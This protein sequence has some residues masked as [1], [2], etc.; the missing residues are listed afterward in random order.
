M[1]DIQRHQIIRK[2]IVAFGNLFNSIP[3]VRYN[4]DGTESERIIVSLSYAAKEQYIKRWYDDPELNSKVQVVIPQLS[5]EMT[6]VNYDASRKQNTNIKNF[7]HTQEGTFSQYNPVPYNFDFELA[8]YSRSIEDATQIV[9]YILPYFTPDYT[10]KVNLIPE[11]GLVKE[12]PII[13]NN[14]I[15]DVVYEGDRESDTRRIIWTFQFTVKG[16]IFGR[17]SDV[18]DKLITHSITSILDYASSDDIFDLTLNPSTGTGTYKVG[19]LVYQG[20][21]IPI[22]T[23]SGRVVSHNTTNNILKIKNINGNFVSNMPLVGSQSRTS[24]LYTQYSPAANNKLI[25]IDTT[26]SPP[27]ANVS[28]NWKANT[29]I[30]EFS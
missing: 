28:S 24:Y 21:S 30:T 18:S 13:L 14:T 11:M 25:Q 27:G 17:V 26:V 16:F 19:E 5:Y 10:I 29:V 3:L 15:R 6:N 1:A 8:L 20:P 4:P 9:E 2:I 12:I 7:A 22:A 23:A